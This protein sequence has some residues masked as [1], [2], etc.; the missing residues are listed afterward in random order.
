MMVRML[1]MMFV[2]MAGPGSSPRRSTRYFR[3]RDRG[4][5]DPLQSPSAN[6]CQEVDTTARSEVT[7]RML[8]AGQHLRA[9]LDEYVAHYNLIAGVPPR[10]T[11]RSA[12]RRRTRRRPAHRL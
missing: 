7:D 6:A 9:V 12:T 4:D 8:I 11:A 2:R 3:P 5:E 1:Y 10:P